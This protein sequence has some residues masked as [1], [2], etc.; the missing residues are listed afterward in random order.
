MTRGQVTTFVARGSWLSRHSLY[1]AI[2]AAFAAA[3]RPCEALFEWTGSEP[4][5]TVCVRPASVAWGWLA[6]PRLEGSCGAVPSPSTGVG[7]LPFGIRVLSLLPEIGR[8]L[9]VSAP[10]SGSRRVGPAAAVQTFWAGGRNGPVLAARRVAYRD[11]ALDSPEALAQLV[12]TR[13]AHAWAE[14]IGAPTRFRPAPARAASDWR[15]GGTRTVPA[16]AWVPL[17]A[18]TADRTAEPVRPSELRSDPAGQGHA[19]VL[20]ASGSGKTFFLADRAAVAGNRGASLVCIDLHGDLAPAIVARL[21]ERARAK[22]VAIDVDA[23]P[24]PGIAGLAGDSERAAAQLVAALKRH[25]PDGTE[26]YWGYRLERV[27]DAFVRL[28]QESG[29]TLVD[30]YQLLTDR[31]R[32]EAARLTTADRELARFLEELGPICRRSPEFLW[33]AAARLSKFLSV[34]RLADLL[35]PSDGGVPV[36]ELLRTG[37]SIL[38]RLP[39]GSLGPEAASF[40][41]TILLARVYLGLAADRPQDRAPPEVLLVLDEAQGF[42]P[43]LLGEIVAE[44]RKFGLRVLLA[45]QL[46]ER[47]HPD[48]RRAAAGVASEVIAFRVPPASAGT[49]GAWLGLPTPEAERWLPTLPVG[50]GVG[51]DPDGS[52]LVAIG[53][54]SAPRSV[55]PDPWTARIGATRAEMGVGAETLPRESGD[56]ATERLLLAGLAAEEERLRLGLAELVRA[57]ERLPGPPIDPAALLDRARSI[58]RAGLLVVAGGEVRLTPAGA[59]A[60]GLSPGTGAVRESAEHRTLLLRA[61]RTFAR[62]GYR[63]EIVRQG[64]FDTTL[65]DATF[66]QLSEATR[67]RPPE[68]IARAIEAARHGWAWRYFHGRDVHLEAEVSGAERRERIRRGV[69]KA[70][71]R[72]AF[73]LFLVGDARRA[74]RVRATLRGLGVGRDRGGVWMLRTGAGPSSAPVDPGRIG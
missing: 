53:P 34:P 27:L 74:A 65:P 39:F 2:H 35:A 33:P 10:G 9:A 22:V 24:F 21:G 56:G 72:G 67:A 59:C 20:G 36:E 15:R 17:S 57:A 19:V 29:G 26:L 7:T 38:V 71:L 42:S 31:H 47:L 40:A 5:P 28:A 63:I 55:R 8:G 43:F 60:L 48:L 58:E 6:D 25:S 68:E 3:P 13:E 14:A 61:F 18:A 49:V 44:G 32:Q 23:P 66:R 69:R 30:V 51:R 46:P 50:E 54:G 1:R 16:E 4:G 37:R 11:L 62:R 52:E 73:V 41:A 64:R 12:G 70:E 45:T